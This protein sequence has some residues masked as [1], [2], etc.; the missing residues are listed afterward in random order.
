MGRYIYPSPGGDTLFHFPTD[1]I[2]ADNI[3]DFTGG[4]GDK[5]VCAF[6]LPAEKRSG[7]AILALIEEI[8]F[9][10]EPAL[11]ER[12]VNEQLP[13]LDD[14]EFSCEP[15]GALDKTLYWM[16]IRFSERRRDLLFDAVRNYRRY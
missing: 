15:M 9:F 11:Y 7:D 8:D 13:I 2:I 5:R 1:L 12:L 3:R 14:E 6:R 16:L 4:I 10:I